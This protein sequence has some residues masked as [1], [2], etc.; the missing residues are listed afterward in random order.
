MNPA[1]NPAKGQPTLILLHAFGASAQAWDSV[2]AELDGAYAVVALDLPGFGGAA[3]HLQ[4]DGVADY[5]DW[6]LRDLAARGVG[7]FV[8]VG[9]SMGGKIALAVALQKPKRL[10][11]LILVAPSPPSPE[12]MEPGARKAERDS[13]GDPA[14]ARAALKEVAGDDIGKAPLDHAVTQ[15]LTAA[16]SA[17]DF[18]LDVG[19]KEDISAQ[20]AGLRLP[21]LVLSGREDAHLGQAAVARHVTP[22]LPQL[23]ETI[24][25]GSGHLVPYEQPRILAQAVKAYVEAL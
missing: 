16:R 1:M 15:R 4:A 12:P 22:H 13:F 2:I 11:A 14:A 18:W 7:D 9:W 24:I 17:W 20:V 10:K 19:S 25:A 6:V 3:D 5:A 21:V 23:T 8:L